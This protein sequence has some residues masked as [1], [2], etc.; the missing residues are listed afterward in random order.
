MDAGVDGDVH[1]ITCFH[2]S[3]DRL[4][5]FVLHICQTTD[6][7]TPPSQPTPPP[8]NNGRMQT[9]THALVEE[10]GEGHQVRPLEVVPVRLPKHLPQVAQRVVPMCG[11]I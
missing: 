3:L 6:Q 7:L 11:S 5:D 8:T 2:L 4:T 1:H 9:R 10:D